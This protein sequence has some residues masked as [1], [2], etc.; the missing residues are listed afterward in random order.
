MLVLVGMSGGV[1]RAL[2][3]TGQGITVLFC[4][5]PVPRLYRFAAAP[6]LCTCLGIWIVADPVCGSSKLLPRYWEAASPAG[7]VTLGPVAHPLKSRLLRPLPGCYLH[8]GCSQPGSEPSPQILGH[9]GRNN[10]NCFL[11]HSSLK[12]RSSLCTYGCKTWLQNLCE[13]TG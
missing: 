5:H 4:S 2:R 7:G 11:K 9:E 10:N 12:C 1:V 3:V 6:S 8:P 13:C